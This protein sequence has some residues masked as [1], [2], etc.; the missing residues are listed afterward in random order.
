[1]DIETFRRIQLLSTILTEEDLTQ[2]INESTL[3]VDT[4]GAHVENGLWQRYAFNAEEI[5]LDDYIEKSENSD[6]TET[7]TK[8][9]FKKN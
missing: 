7:C 6:A 5:S 9:E 1:M 2:F 4:P 3:V 8:E